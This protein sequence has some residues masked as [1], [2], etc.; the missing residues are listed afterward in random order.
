MEKIWTTEPSLLFK[1]RTD[2]TLCGPGQWTMFHLLSN[3]WTW[4]QMKQKPI[5]KVTLLVIGLD[6][7]GK[8]ALVRVIKRACSCDMTP[9]ADPLKTELRVDRFDVTLVDLAG[10]QQFRGLWRNYYTEAHGIIYVVDSSD[11]ERVEE[12]KWILASVLCHPKI[13]GK[14]LLLLANKQ[15]K[16]S[17]LLPSELIEALSLEK[18]VNENKSLCRIEPC[19]AATD[20][21]NNYDWVVLKAVRWLLFT[22]AINYTTLNLRVQHDAGGQQALP[23]HEHRK[24][25]ELPRSRVRA[26]NKEIV[27]SRNKPN[28]GRSQLVEYKTLRSVQM[29]PLQPIHN[30]LSQKDDGLK[31]PKSKK[32]KK[33]KMKIKSSVS[34]E[35]VVE[36][37]RK[38]EAENRITSNVSI[39]HSNRIAQEHHNSQEEQSPLPGPSK[40]KKKKKIKTK[41]KM[42]VKNKIKSQDT[43]SNM[44][45]GDLSSTF[46][47]YRKA[48]LTLKRRQQQQSHPSNISP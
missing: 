33:V 4:I 14:P 5:R 23:E 13:S 37:E 25:K 11:L 35:S 40:K 19:A 43:T 16:S 44:T 7:A 27:V 48:M 34:L 36:A 1:N 9:T 24:K 8:T 17:T 32:K 41:K 47:L 3:C 31:A 21:C 39:L 26:E 38:L 22:I 46:D 30:I 28:E 29:R 45:N 2:S 12:A 15:D 20:Y 18:L 42:P 6:N 10:G